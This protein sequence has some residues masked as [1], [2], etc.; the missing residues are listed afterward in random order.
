MHNQQK[1]LQMIHLA[2]CG[3]MVI[4]YI[5]IGN[6][7]DVENLTVPVIDAASSVYLLI[8]MV[9][10][11]VSTL[12]YKSALKKIDPKIDLKEK[13]TSYQ[14]ASIIRWA[15]LEAGAFVIL[16]LKPDFILFGLLIIGYMIF[17]RPTEARFK[18]DVNHLHLNK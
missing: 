16:F 3:G 14:T 12:L 7:T 17:L 13:Y 8:P 1:M 18:T 2:L 10:I 5:L 9:A 11:F 4:S 15:L 6:L